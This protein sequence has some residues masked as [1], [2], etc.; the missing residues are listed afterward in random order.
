[1]ES[2]SSKLSAIHK[3]LTIL[4]WK[5]IAQFAVFVSIIA[6]AWILYETR[7]TVYNFSSPARLATTISPVLKLSKKSIDDL[8]L[9]VNKSNLIVGIQ[10]TVVDFQRNTRTVIFTYTDDRNIAEIYQDY[11]KRGLV[12]L[13]IFNNDVLNNKRMVELINGEFICNPFNE[14]IAYKIMPSASKYISYVCAN[15]IPP[16]YSKFTGL[17]T[18]YTN[19]IPIPEEIDQIRTMTRNLSS[20]IYD[21]DFK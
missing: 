20:S 6:L 14:T 18:V 15:G 16:L 5:K 17:I 2:F 3:F 19:R 7:I 21:R 4:T 11:E 10:V 13:P 9:V 12:E 1:M 8:T